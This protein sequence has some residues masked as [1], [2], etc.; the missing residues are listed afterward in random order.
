MRLPKLLLNPVMMIHVWLWCA[1][2]GFHIAQA[3]GI[4]EGERAFFFM[5]VAY[6]LLG[7]S[8]LAA[9]P[10]CFFSLRRAVREHDKSMIV[11]SSAGALMAC[12]VLA[13]GLFI[14]YLIGASPR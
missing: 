2:I 3:L 8:A 10:V 6:F 13:Y 9:A 4:A 14:F 5:I 12:S 1:V 7:L 11:Q